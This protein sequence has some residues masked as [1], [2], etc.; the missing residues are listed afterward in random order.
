MTSV[1]IRNTRFISVVRTPLFSYAH[2]PAAAARH[3]TF[4]CC[5]VPPQQET[6][7]SHARMPAHDA[8]QTPTKPK[9]PT[10]LL[11][12]KTHAYVAAVLCVCM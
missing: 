1:K 2:I 5:A 7:G 9:V 3:V 11:P 10:N 4:V 8:Y 12:A 6:N